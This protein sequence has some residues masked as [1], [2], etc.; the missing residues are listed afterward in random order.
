MTAPINFSAESLAQEAA[1]AQHKLRAGLDTLREVGDIDYGATA[2]E[3][4]WRDGKVVLY[5]FRGDK[6]PIAKVPLLIAYALVNRPYMVDLQ[7]D[8]S[9]VRGLLERGQDVYIL[10][11]GY[12]DRS[13]RYLELEDYI[14]RFLGGAVDHLRREY[15]MDSVNLLGIC[16]GGAFSLCYSALNPGKVRNLITMVTPVDFHTSDN[17][18]SNWTRGLDIDQFVDTLGNVPA[19][20]MNWCY[21]TLKPWRLFVQKYVGLIDILDDKRALEDFLRMEKWIFDSPDQAGEAFRQF[22]KQFYQGNGFVNGGIDIGGRAVDLGYVQMPVLNIY[23]E[24]DHL[25]PPAA[26]KAL[27]DLVGTQDYSELSFKGGHIG[28]YV[29]GRA[30]R[31]VPGAIHDWL[32]ERSR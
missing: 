2:R 6:A 28:I 1:A 20:V 31:E 32:S 18:L 16:Q 4:V 24:Q 30:Q 3:E 26:S 8:K 14:Q 12:P 19:D 23:A 15:R 21:L 9:I 22:I 29:S 11:W 7:T 13:D 27:A 25:V 10:D 17:M 5:R